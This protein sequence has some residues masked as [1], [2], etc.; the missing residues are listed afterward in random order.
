[1]ESYHRHRLLLLLIAAKRRR[2]CDRHAE[3]SR[4]L[5]DGRCVVISG[6]QI[7]VTAEIRAQMRR[8][9][10]SRSSATG[11]AILAAAHAR[12]LHPSSALQA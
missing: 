4:T 11:H 12:C 3:G 2:P 9:R 8:R 1:V 6:R 7:S 5:G 10:K